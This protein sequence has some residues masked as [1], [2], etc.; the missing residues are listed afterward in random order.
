MALAEAGA[1]ADRGNSRVIFKVHSGIICMIQERGSGACSTPAGAGANR[2]NAST[3]SNMNILV[4]V[5]C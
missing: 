4:M 2:G 5:I 1:G 3:D